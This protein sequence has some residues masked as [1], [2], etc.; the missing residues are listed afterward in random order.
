MCKS[1]IDEA[2]GNGDATEIL[3]IACEA[4]KKENKGKYSEDGKKMCLF[5]DDDSQQERNNKENLNTFAECMKAVKAKNSQDFSK[6]MSG[7]ASVIDAGLSSF[8][9]ATGLDTTEMLGNIMGSADAVS[10]SF[11]NWV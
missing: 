3:F 10:E 2:G 6:I 8:D 9:E 5:H 4:D 11:T 1:K 7:E